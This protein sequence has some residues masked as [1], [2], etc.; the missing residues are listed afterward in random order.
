MQ[1][2]LRRRL[3]ELGEREDQEEFLDRVLGSVSS[4]G[5]GLS[6]QQI[7]DAVHSGRR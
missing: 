7:L 6:A 4:S 3:V 5:S 1:E 2:Y